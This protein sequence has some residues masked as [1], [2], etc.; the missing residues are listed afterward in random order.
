MF[1]NLDKDLSKINWFPII[2]AHVAREPIKCQR[3]LTK[4]IERE[5][6]DKNI[7]DML[8]CEKMMLEAN[9]HELIEYCM[10]LYWESRKDMP[11][12]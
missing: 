1:D 5:L 12:D 10:E 3:A 7:G 9:L 6:A 11:N 4:T 2:K 8:Y